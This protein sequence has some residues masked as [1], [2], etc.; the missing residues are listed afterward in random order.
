LQTAELRMAPDLA[1]QHY[2]TTAMQHY[3]ATLQH[4]S[5]TTPQ[6]HSTTTPQHHNTAPLQHHNTATLHNNTTTLSTCSDAP[7]PWISHNVTTNDDR[8]RLVVAMETEFASCE[9]RA[10]GVPGFTARECICS[11]SAELSVCLS[12]GL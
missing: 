3:T 8:S 9:V 11:Y 7:Y 12:V 1:P 5:N 6:H 2:N 10:A 4:C